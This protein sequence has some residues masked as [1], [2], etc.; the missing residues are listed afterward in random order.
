MVPRGRQLGGERAHQADD[1]VLG[2]AVGGD[3]GV[4]LEAG[5][6]GDEHDAA[7]AALA[8]NVG[9]RRAGGEEGAGEVH[10]EHA[11]PMGEIDAA[12]G[13][14]LGGAGVGDEDVDGAVR[15]ARGLHHRFAC[16][17]PW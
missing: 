8:R 15:G 9:Q 3:V 1:A 6:G 11:L 4:A 2:G 17:L 7:L 14:A 5:G 12:E 13:R 10:V 16:R